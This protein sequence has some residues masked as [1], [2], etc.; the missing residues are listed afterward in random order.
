ME[1][2]KTNIEEKKNKEKEM[3]KR[4]NDNIRKAQK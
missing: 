4:F 2:N 3:N 1:D